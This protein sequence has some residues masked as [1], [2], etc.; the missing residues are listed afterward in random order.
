MVQVHNSI[1]ETL[2]NP[3]SFLWESCFEKTKIIE[4]NEEWRWAMGRTLTII[5]LLFSSVVYADYPGSKVDNPGCVQLVSH[6]QLG[7]EWYLTFSNY[8]G[9][10][11]TINLCIR[12][13]DGS[14]DLKRGTRI[15]DFGTLKQTVYRKSGRDMKQVTWTASRYAPSVPEACQES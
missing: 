5:V 9:T 4:Y 8:C 2:N 10:G 7:S 13:D 14:T 11:M 12:Y 1:C 15:P 3:I 6:Y